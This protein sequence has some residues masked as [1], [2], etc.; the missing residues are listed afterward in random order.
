VTENSLQDLK[1]ALNEAREATKNLT[2]S[3]TRRVLTKAKKLEVLSEKNA[4]RA[5]TK[6]KHL[7]VSAQAKAERTARKLAGKAA[8]AVHDLA[9]KLEDASKK[10]SKS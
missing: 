8:P 7:A 2:A 9:Q 6:A 10:P 3:A 5:A 1:K 4:S